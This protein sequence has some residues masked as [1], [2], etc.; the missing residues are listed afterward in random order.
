M[1]AN[2]FFFS[3]VRKGLNLLA[4]YQFNNNLIDDA[5]GYNLT[6]IDI[7]YNNDSAVF[8]G[9]TSEARRSDTNDIFSFTDGVNDLPFRIET[10]I[11]FNA[12][13]NSFQFIVMKRDSNQ[14]LREWQLFYEN[15]INS[16]GFSL[17]TDTLGVNAIVVKNQIT[18]QLN[19]TYNVVISYDGSKTLDGLNISVN[20]VEG[21][22]KTEIGNYT[23]MIKTG[24]S[25]TLGI[26][27][28]TSAFDFDGEI[29]YL[30]IYK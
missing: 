14:T 2:K 3:Q 18:P 11:K 17:Y 22:N 9:V 5:N 13:T 23:G 19:T 16:F 24:S 21:T 30:K 12:F 10:S 1:G 26:A 20:G 25:L 6:G 15:S 27:T 4:D 28:W 8:N 7:T 29:D